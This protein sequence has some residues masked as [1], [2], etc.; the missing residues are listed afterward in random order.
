MAEVADTYKTIEEPSE[1]IYKEKGSKFIA[2]AY[3]VRTEEEVKAILTKLREEYYDA[4]HHCYAYILGAKKESWRAND[5]GEPSGTAGKPIHGQLLSF[6][7]TNVL[8]VVIRYFGGTKLGV[9]GLIN[10]Y[11]TAT[12]DALSN[13]KII[14][15]TVDTIYKLTFGYVTMNDVMKLIKE[16]NLEFIDQHFDNTCFIR[17]R[18][19]KS[20]ESE[21]TS[22]CSKIDGLVAD[23]EYDD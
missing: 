17:L 10:A 9:S 14:T 2:K 18:V 22:R 20:L 16:L 21:F 23:F 19:R 8:V 7:V 12:Q 15:K 3:P 1:G 4:R 11:K 5:D 13:A 6:D